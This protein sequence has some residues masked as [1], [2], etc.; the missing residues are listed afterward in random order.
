MIGNGSARPLARPNAPSACTLV[1]MSWL[2]RSWLLMLVLGTLVSPR[3]ASAHSP[4]GLETRVGGLDLAAQVIVG[5]HGLASAGSYLGNPDGYDENASG[6]S[7]AAGGGGG[8]ARSFFDGT[9]YTPKV[10]QQMR[11]GV[12]E[13]HL[14]PESVTAFESAG[15][16]RTITGGDGVARQMLE[17]PGS[18]TTSRGT[19]MDGVFQFIKEADGAINHRLFVPRTP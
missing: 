10:L 19:V 18:Y 5:V 17:I 3:L 13:F 1:G 6:C 9:R 4:L 16:V 11:G 14:F 7:L 12:G 15:T 8:A 2:R